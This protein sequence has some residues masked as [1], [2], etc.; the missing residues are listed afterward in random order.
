MLNAS[1]F[2][3]KLKAWQLVLLHLILSCSGF[4]GSKVRK[5]LSTVGYILMRKTFFALLLLAVIKVA[6]S[7]IFQVSEAKVKD[8]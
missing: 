3:T 7:P 8:K 1:T 5:I 2:I 4:V 6:L